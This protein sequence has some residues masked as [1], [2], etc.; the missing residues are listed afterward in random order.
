MHEWVQTTLYFNTD[1]PILQTCVVLHVDADDL[2]IELTVLAV[3][4]ADEGCGGP[5]GH[6]TDA[7]LYPRYGLR[8][9]DYSIVFVCHLKRVFIFSCAQN[10][11]FFIG[12]KKL[13]GPE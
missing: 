1:L 12:W 4:V 8:E 10:K 13:L 3:V 11:H 7:A 5:E 9:E 2:A 6:E